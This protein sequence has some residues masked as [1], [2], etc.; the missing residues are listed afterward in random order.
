M[1]FAMSH[2]KGDRHKFYL[3]PMNDSHM[4]ATVF[5]LEH[6][7]IV[8]FC[9]TPEPHFYHQSLVQTI[10]HAKE[11]GAKVI[12]VSQDSWSFDRNESQRYAIEV[13]RSE[14]NCE[15]VC[16]LYTSRVYGPRQ[17]IGDP[18]VLA[19]SRI[20]DGKWPNTATASNRP[21]QWLYIKDLVLAVEKIIDS[22]DISGEF[23]AAASHIAS[24]HEVTMCLQ[25]ISE[26]RKFTFSNYQDF[27]HTDC[28]RLI[29]IGWS[30][31]HSLSEALE[32]TLAWY[33]I[34][35]WARVQQL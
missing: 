26:G 12:Y 19:I 3:T 33:A 28:S 5:R 30:P 32:H 13:C 20:L 23:R 18:L 8:V 4:A 29:N 6:P 10:W 17:E 15:N 2:K 24:E 9:K 27:I 34:N 22:G 1:Q 31:K 16:A 35:P 7:D 25:M 11:C 21:K 14:S